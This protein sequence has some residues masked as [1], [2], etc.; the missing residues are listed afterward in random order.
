M[1]EVD[2]LVDGNAYVARFVKIAVNVVHR[3]GEASNELPGILR[4]WFGPQAG[5]PG[6]NHTVLFELIDDRWVMRAALS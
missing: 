2:V 6:T 5:H 4:G 1:G 3:P